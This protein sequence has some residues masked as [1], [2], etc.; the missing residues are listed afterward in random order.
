MKK[1]AFGLLVLVFVLGSINTQA[2][3][4]SLPVMGILPFRCASSSDAGA[5]RQAESLVYELFVNSKRLNIVE[6]EFFEDLEGEK[7]R[8]SQ[9][10]FIDGSTIEKTKAEGAEYLLLGK[11]ADC[12]V[13]REVDD[14]GDV[15]YECDLSVNIRIVDVETSE[16]KYS[17]HWENKG[18]LNSGILNI[19]LGADSEGESIDKAINELKKPVMNFLDKYYPIKGVIIDVVEQQRGEAKRVMLKMGSEDGVKEKSKYLVFESKTRQVGDEEVSYRKE[20]GE[21]KVKEVNGAHV[22]IAKVRKGGDLILQK[23]TTGAD[24]V[25]TTKN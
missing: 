24:L 14:D 9:E 23:F 15:S 4:E 5:A 18:L 19:S 22:S 10:D 25:I 6:R 1:N 13:S 16:V 2:Q 20:I 21:L 7:W 8:Q 12:D 11:I 17:D 3:D